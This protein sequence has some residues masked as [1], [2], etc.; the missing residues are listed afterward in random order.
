MTNTNLATR[1][2]GIKATIQQIEAKYQRT[3]GSVTLLAVSKTKPIEA[4]LQAVAV[5]QREFGESYLQEALEKIPLLVNEKLCWHFIGP[6]QKNKTKSIAENFGWV[7]SVDRAI[8]A[9]RL[10]KQRPKDLSP[11][12]VCIQVNVD[13]EDSKSG[14]SLNDVENLANN[15]KTLPNIVLRGLMAI[16]SN[17]HD[18]TKQ[19]HSFAQLRKKLDQLNTNGFN[20]DTLSMGM[21]ND[22]EPAIAEGATIVRVGSAIF[23]QRN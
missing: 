18:T 8:T 23:G 17:T 12:Q 2:T 5:G 6:I 21:S 14:V 20:L 10:S 7:H 3:K 11:L 13:N 16:P 15:I 22:L 9:E 4:I 1:L 19:R